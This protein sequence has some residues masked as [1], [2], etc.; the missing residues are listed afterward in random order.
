MGRRH[1]EVMK[2]P[3]HNFLLTLDDG[4]YRFPKDSRGFLYTSYR[5]KEE[6][7]NTKKIRFEE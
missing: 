7:N 4:Y 5:E 3:I 1:V 6:R 2:T